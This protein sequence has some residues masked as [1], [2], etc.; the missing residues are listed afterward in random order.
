MSRLTNV[1]LFARFSTS[2]L[3]VSNGVL[4][5][6]WTVTELAL[7][8]LEVGIV[9]GVRPTSKM[10]IVSDDIVIGRGGRS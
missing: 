3:L 9:R 4:G 7:L 1:A 6:V 8:V 2:D 5:H 10:I